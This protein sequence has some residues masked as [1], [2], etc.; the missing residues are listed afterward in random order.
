MKVGDLVKF[1]TKSWVMRRDYA[2]PGVVLGVREAQHNGSQRMRVMW[3]DGSITFEHGCYLKV[4][5]K[6]R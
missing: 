5:S 6:S 1:E 2:N 4:I 3:S